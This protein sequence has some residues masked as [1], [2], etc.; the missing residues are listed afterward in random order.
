MKIID[1]QQGSP[2]WLK[3]RCGIPTASNFDKIL[4]ADG[5]VSK[6]RTKYLYQLAGET[7]TGIAE[8]TYQNAAMLRGKEMEAEARQLYQ[9]ITGEEVKEVGFCLAEGYGASPD[10]LVGKEGLLEIKCPLIS[11]HVSYLLENKLP[12]EYFIQTQGQ[13]LVTGKK[14]VDFISYYGSMKPLIVRTFRDEK[15]IKSLR[16]ELELFVNEL[17]E[18]INK[19]K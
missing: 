8:E 1:C 19:I 11:T 12:S 6:Q 15:F 5:K 13:L 10:G 3:A 18:V 7:I 9:L 2:E 17:K 4:C 14:W 16:V